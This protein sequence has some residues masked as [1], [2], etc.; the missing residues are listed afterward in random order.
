MGGSPHDDRVMALAL[1]Q[2][3]RRHVWLEEYRPPEEKPGKGTMGHYLR[4][5]MHEVKPVR[6][7]FIG[8][9]NVRSSW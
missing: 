8:T 6:G 3:A 4:Q 1:A 9:H 5:L 2:E 7:G